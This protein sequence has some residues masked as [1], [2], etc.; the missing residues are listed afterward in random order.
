M[1]ILWKMPPLYCNM[2]Q[3]HFPPLFLR[4]VKFGKYMK[5]NFNAPPDRLPPAKNLKFSDTDSPHCIFAEIFLVLTE[6]KS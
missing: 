1:E 5:T 2:A 4:S 6:K 3:L